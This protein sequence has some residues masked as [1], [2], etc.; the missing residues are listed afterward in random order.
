MHLSECINGNFGFATFLLLDT[1]VQ[2]D[3]YSLIARCYCTS[4]TGDHFWVEAVVTKRPFFQGVY[5]FDGEKPVAEMVAHV[6]EA[7]KRLS[8]QEVRKPTA[9]VWYEKM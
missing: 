9:W 2:G 1:Q 6:S 8:T 4:P 3:T 5:S 7:A